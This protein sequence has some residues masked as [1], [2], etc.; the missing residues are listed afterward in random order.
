MNY[1]QMHKLEM[2]M[3]HQVKVELFSSWFIVNYINSH[4]LQLVSDMSTLKIDV[5]NVATGTALVKVDESTINELMN[6]SVSIWWM[7]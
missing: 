3:L 2:L 4:C 6:D 5:A 1:I 7:V